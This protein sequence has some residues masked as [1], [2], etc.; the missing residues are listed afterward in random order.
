MGGCYNW[1]YNIFRSSPLS[2]SYNVRD[3]PQRATS[4]FYLKDSQRP[5]KRLTTEHVLQ[6]S[7]YCNVRIEAEWTVEPPVRDNTKN[8]QTAVSAGGFEPAIPARE[9]PQTHA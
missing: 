6:D 4:Q 5:K 2:T 3:M 8:R 7:F 9:R 1:W